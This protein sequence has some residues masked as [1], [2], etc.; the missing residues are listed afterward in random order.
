MKTAD[1]IFHSFI[2]AKLLAIG[3]VVFAV[4][5]QSKL[6]TQINLNES[7]AITTASTLQFASVAQIQTGA[8]PTKPLRKDEKI[9]VDLNQPDTLR[10]NVQFNKKIRK[11]A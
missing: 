9:S 1:K 7:F 11:I 3:L 4:T 2:F 10:A 8:I 6:K 5:S